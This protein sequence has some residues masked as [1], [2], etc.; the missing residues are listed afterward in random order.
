MKLR[1]TL[2]SMKKED[3]LALLNKDHA[4]DGEKV[5]EL[6]HE[7]EKEEYSS[8]CDDCLGQCEQ[9]S[10]GDEGFTVCTNCEQVE[11]KTHE[12]TVLKDLGVAYLWGKK[13]IANSEEIGMSQ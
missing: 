6:F 7:N 5:L 13:W 2:E 8:I 1:Q 4:Q 12:V 11:G 10:R 3:L 9:R